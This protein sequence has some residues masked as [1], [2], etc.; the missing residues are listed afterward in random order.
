MLKA[1][2]SSS[3]KADTIQAA[4]EAAN[5]IKATLSDIDVAFVYSSVGHDSRQLIDSIS[6]AIPGIQVVGNTSFTGVIT[7]DGFVGGDD[8]FVG[9]LAL[10]DDELTVGVAGR[11]KDGTARETG[12]AVALEAL[13]AAGKSVTG[14]IQTPDYFYMVANPG[15]EEFFLKGIEDVIG[16]VPFF[17]GSAADNTIEGYW[18]LFTDKE[19]IT[20]GVAVAFFYTEGTNKFANLFTGAY[21]ETTDR[22]IITKV[23][24]NRTLEEIDGVPA[25]KKYAEWRGVEPDS[26]L[27]ATLLA[28]TVVSPLGVKDR[29]GDLT[30]IRHPMFGND[31]YS[32]NIGAN[33]AVG[34]AILRVEA[35]VDEIIAAA[36]ANVTNLIEKL[37]HKPSVLHLVHCGGRRAAIAD[38]I[39]EVYDVIKAAAGDIPFLVEFTFGEYGYEDDGNNTTG[40]L[41]LSFTAFA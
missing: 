11:S 7:P 10:S 30:A 25:L 17:G 32:M 15:E 24:D 29:L 9:I 27:G 36:G 8:N 19:I 4:Y 34:T 20:D 33:L 37:G 12:K 28:E 39:D 22:G 23:R 40:G 13:Q 21:N 6:E 26:L 3:N 31:D 38:R 14:K 1:K 5:G 35:S 18:S 41:M 2:V 16:R